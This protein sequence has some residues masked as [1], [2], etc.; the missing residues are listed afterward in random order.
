MSKL[1]KE[2]PIEKIVARQVSL[3]QQ[4]H[5]RETVYK[6]ALDFPSISIS[7][8]TGSGEEEV[9]EELKRILGWQ[10]YDKNIVERIANNAA[11]NAKLVEAIDERTRSEFRNWIKAVFQNS[12]IQSDQYMRHLSEVILSIAK[13]GRAIIIGRGANFI[14]PKGQTLDVRIIAP[15]QHRAYYT[16]DKLSIDYEKAKRMVIYSDNERQAFLHKFFNRTE[17]D[18]LNYDVIINTGNMNYKTAARVI[19]EALCSK[20]AMKLENLKA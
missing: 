12:L 10:V 7:R 4:S 6:K 8:E 20:F 17:F 1:A 3:G 18:P 11:L 9:V 19:V 13:H 5:R 14:L 2:I 15:L 16:A